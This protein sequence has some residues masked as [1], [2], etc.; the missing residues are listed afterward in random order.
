MYRTSKIMY[1]QVSAQFTGIDGLQALYPIAKC[2]GTTSSNVE[3]IEMWLLAQLPGVP[4]PVNC[5]INSWNQVCRYT[6]TVFNVCN[7]G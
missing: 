4:T 3:F 5:Y 6:D 1:Q 7:L 2:T